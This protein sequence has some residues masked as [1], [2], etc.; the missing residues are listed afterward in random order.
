MADSRNEF[1]KSPTPKFS[2]D[3]ALGSL[4]V[5]YFFAQHF[6]ALD[7]HCGKAGLRR[8]TSR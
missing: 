7:F 1:Q 8:L 3:N 6:F 2:L 5:S 4:I